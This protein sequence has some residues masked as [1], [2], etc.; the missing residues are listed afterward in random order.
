M[1]STW[2]GEAQHHV[3]HAHVNHFT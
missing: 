3:S 1:T 2:Y